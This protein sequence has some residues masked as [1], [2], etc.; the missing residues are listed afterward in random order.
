MD[1]KDGLL[2]VTYDEYKQLPSFVPFVCAEGTGIVPLDLVEAQVTI[3]PQAL[4][5]F[6]RFRPI[7]DPANFLR[8]TYE[9]IRSYMRE[10][11]IVAYTWNGPVS[12]SPI[13]QNMARLPPTLQ[14]TY[15][16][17]LGLVFPTEKA[18]A[19]LVYPSEAE[20]P[21]QRPEVEVKVFLNRSKCP[22]CAPFCQVTCTPGQMQFVDQTGD[23]NCRT[24]TAG[25][26]SVAS[27]AE[28]RVT[29]TECARCPSGTFTGAG[30]SSCSRCPPGA[31][32]SL[33]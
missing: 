19:K 1:M 21:C 26:Y 15:D 8:D 4:V 6:F 17:R 11:S 23:K 30:A 18:S 20:M 3:F 25:H 5:T 27:E 13:G 29:A 28:A 33:S 9:D 32:S 10:G 7:L 31:L 16:E 22:L 24:C 12:F 2:Y 14:F